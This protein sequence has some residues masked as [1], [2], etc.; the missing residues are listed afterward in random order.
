ME[1]HRQLLYITND[2]KNLGE[3]M[4]EVQARAVVDN[5]D[6]Y[7]KLLLY[8]AA[9]FGKDLKSKVKMQKLM[10]FCKY[11]LPEVFDD[12]L[13]FEAHKK[14]PYSQDVDE[15]LLSI[16]DKNLIDL[17][18]CAPTVLGQEVSQYVVP[19]EPV[20]SIVDNYKKFICRLNEKEL[21]TMIYVSFPEYQRNSDVWDDIKRNRVDTATSLMRKGAVSFSKAVEISGMDQYEFERHLIDR[22]VRW[23]VV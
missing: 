6:S 4:S 18:S 12:S 2:I 14:G 15:Y 22:K 21:L 11:A 20:K 23:R 9:A 10:F 19:M 13:D 8:A 17:P 5:M 7:E 16:E 1:E 3:G